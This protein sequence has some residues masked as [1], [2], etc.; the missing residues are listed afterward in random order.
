MTVDELSDALDLPEME[1]ISFVDADA[2]VEDAALPSPQ[3]FIEAS[4]ELCSA[5]VAVGFA[6]SRVFGENATPA[7]CEVGRDEVLGGLHLVVRVP[8]HGLDR[9][10]YQEK[11]AQFQDETLRAVAPDTLRRM[12]ITTRRDA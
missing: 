8:V 9:A 6:A 7:E 5:L 10:G 11:R 2:S 4:P 3:A 1:G 12:V